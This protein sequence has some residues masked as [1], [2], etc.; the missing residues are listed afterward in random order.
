M[1]GKEVYVV[2]VDD[3]YD[4]A[5]H[6]SCEVFASKA[7][8]KKELERLKLSALNDCKGLVFEEWEDEFSYYIDGDY[9][10]N[11]YDVS[12]VTKTIS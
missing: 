4:Y 12:I 9:T 6:V 3:V 8:A 2:L 7:D 5:N 10:S 11:H 1:K